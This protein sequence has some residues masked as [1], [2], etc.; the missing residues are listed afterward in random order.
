M[1]LSGVLSEMEGRTKVILVLVHETVTLGSCNFLVD[2]VVGSS[3]WA[4]ELGL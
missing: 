4:N 2:E 1:S 3:P